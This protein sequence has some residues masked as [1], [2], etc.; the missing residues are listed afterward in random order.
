MAT[1]PPGDGTTP[2]GKYKGMTKKEPLLQVTKDDGSTGPWG[3]DPKWLSQPGKRIKLSNAPN[4]DMDHDEAQKLADNAPMHNQ[5]KQDLRKNISGGQITPDQGD[6][7][8]SLKKAK[9]MATP[10]PATPAQ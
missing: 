10:A 8:K 4:D 1:T 9:S 5:A 7:L 6:L 3:N 2:A